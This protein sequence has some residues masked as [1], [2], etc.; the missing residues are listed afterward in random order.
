[1]VD[2]KKYTWAAGKF[3]PEMSKV[4]P[5]ITQNHAFG[6]GIKSVSRPRNYCRA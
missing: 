3:A 2:G 1:M 4:A 6:G 5:E